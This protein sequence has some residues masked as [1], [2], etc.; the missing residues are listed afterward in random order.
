MYKQ[1]VFKTEKTDKNLICT[2]YITN[3]RKTQH[4]EKTSLLFRAQLKN[5]EMDDFQ[6]TQMD[7]SQLPRTTYLIT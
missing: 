5:L 2:V 7:N 4:L 6:S 1:N 3:W